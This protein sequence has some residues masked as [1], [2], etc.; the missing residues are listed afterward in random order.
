MEKLEYSSMDF[1]KGK[2]IFIDDDFYKIIPKS[3]KSILDKIIDNQDQLST[4]HILIPDGYYLTQDDRLCYK[5]RN[6]VDYH[7][8]YMLLFLEMELDIKKIS[9][10]LAKSFLELRGIGLTYWDLHNQNGL[11]DKDF[12]T[13]LIDMDGVQLSGEDDLYKLALKRLIELIFQMMTT[14]DLIFGDFASS[15]EKIYVKYKAFEVYDK[16]VKN[17]LHDIANL[18]KRAEKIDIINLIEKICEEEKIE[19]IKKRVYLPR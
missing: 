15:L 12:N 3:K 18:E 17:K 13:M 9:L 19:E 2:Y 10:D 16:K 1:I 6:L 14:K 8:I 11:V 7:T 4:N 5:T